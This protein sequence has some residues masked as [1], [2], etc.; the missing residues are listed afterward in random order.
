[1]LGEGYIQRRAQLDAL[2]LEGRSPR[3]RVSE[4]YLGGDG[5]DLLDV[6]R[7]HGLEGVVAKRTTARYECGCRSPEWT[8]TALLNTQEVIIG[9]WSPG[10]GRR[11][12]A[13]GW[14]CSGGSPRAGEFNDTAGCGRDRG[15]HR[16]PESDTRESGSGDPEG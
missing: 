16:E 2:T 13:Q 5:H 9:G 3:I 4:N 15:D 7:S 1:M 6:V 8:K 10:Q 12:S 11:A 14:S